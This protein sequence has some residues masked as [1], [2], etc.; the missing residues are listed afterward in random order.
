MHVTYSH[1]V[2]EGWSHRFLGQMYAE[3]LMRSSPYEQTKLS[4]YWL[5]RYGC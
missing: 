1:E 3:V 5:I 4:T 2:K